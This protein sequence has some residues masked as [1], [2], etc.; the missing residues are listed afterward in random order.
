MSQDQ[1]SFSNQVT[2]KNNLNTFD[3]LNHE[4]NDDENIALLLLGQGEDEDDPVAEN[5]PAQGAGEES[6]SKNP[7]RSNQVPNQATASNNSKRTNTLDLN[8]NT[9]SNSLDQKK[10]FESIL[11]QE[12][13][14]KSDNPP[15][16][17]NANRSSASIRRRADNAKQI[18]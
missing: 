8:N 5:S 4:S 6:K 7:A 9:N 18:V 14:V 13:P 17:A 15:A 16:D 2:S 12:N 1:P 11:E 3:N 10:I